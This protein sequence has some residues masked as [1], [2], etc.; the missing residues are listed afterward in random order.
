ME[1]EVLD[2]EEWTI[3]PSN[4]FLRKKKWFEKKDKDVMVAVMMNFARV[5]SALNDGVQLGEVRKWGKVRG[6]GDR[7]LLEIDQRG[8]GKLP[9][10]RLYVYPHVETRTLYFITMGYKDTQD[11]DL[12][13]CKRYID[14]LEAQDEKRK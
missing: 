13:D 11:T 2:S 10:A 14:K 1:R 8:R 12:K 3:L 7:G 6:G 5:F 4:L 9:E